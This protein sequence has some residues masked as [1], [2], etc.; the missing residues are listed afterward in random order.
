MCVCVCVCVCIF[1]SIYTYKHTH[2][3]C[4]C[5]CVCVYASVR[6]YVRV[7]VFVFVCFVCLRQVDGESEREN[8]RSYGFQ[9]YFRLGRRLDM[10]YSGNDI[11]TTR[12]NTFVNLQIRVFYGYMFV[13]NMSQCKIYKSYINRC[14]S[15]MTNWQWNYRPRRPLRPGKSRQR[16]S[17]DIC[18]GP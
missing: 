7:F 18:N 16:W 2:I 17:N 3:Y 5:V 4:V 10:K 6:M 8:T 13:V 9:W 1:I 15:L 11:R 12:H 14:V